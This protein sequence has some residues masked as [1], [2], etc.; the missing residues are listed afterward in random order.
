MIMVI[1]YRKMTDDDA[2]SFDML[3]RLGFFEDPFPPTWCS[4]QHTTKDQFRNL[5]T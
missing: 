3:D 2:R 4:V 5:Q 1:G